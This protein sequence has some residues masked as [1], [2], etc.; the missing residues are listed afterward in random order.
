MEASRAIQGELAAVRAPGDIGRAHV[1]CFASSEQ[2]RPSRIS[3][4]ETANALIVGVEN[5]DA[6][7]G[8]RFDQL[9]F[10]AGDAFDRIE[11]LDVRRA[12][13][14]DHADV[15]LGY[16]REIAN[17]AGMVH[18]DFEHS[19]LRVVRHIEDAQRHADV[20]VEITA[21]LANAQRRREQRRDGLFGHRLAGA[22]GDADHA[23]G[24]VRAPAFARPP[25]QLLQRGE[26][27]FHHKLS[28][29]MVDWMRHYGRERASLKRR[30]DVLVPIVCFTRQGEK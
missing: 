13:I 14:G 1:R 11:T 10:R 2:D 24:S 16:A 19:H 27:V 7:R 20:V 28:A 12:D 23:A 21:R 5:G 6:I 26:R 3:L 17:F 9:V 15:R 25:R 30:G 4:R 22:A 18:A 29:G 8:Q